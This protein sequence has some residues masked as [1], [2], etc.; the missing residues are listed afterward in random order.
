MDGLY[1]SVCLLI[2]LQLRNKLS[3]VDG[4]LD[5]LKFGY[6]VLQAEMELGLASVWKLH[7]INLDHL[8]P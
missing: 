6:L 1:T 8:S 5:Q 7:L 4:L 2:L 3:H